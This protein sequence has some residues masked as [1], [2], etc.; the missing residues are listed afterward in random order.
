ML[1]TGAS[2][3]IGKAIAIRLAKEGY[4]LYLCCKNNI[5]S[6]NEFAVELS[7]NYKINCIPFKCDVSKYED[8]SDMFEKIGRI[9]I[10]INNAGIAYLGL[11]TDMNIDDWNS[12]INTNLTSAFLTSKL[13]IPKMLA[14]GE[15]K[16]INIS[17]MWGSVGAST[18]VAY[19]ASK[20]GLNGFTKALSKELA[21]SNISVNAISCGVID[22][23]MNRK[24]LTDEDL[25]NLEEE[26]PYG[27]MGT[28]SEV[29]NLVLSVIS[30]PNYMTG[31]IIMIDGGYI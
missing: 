3:G 1:V 25:Q 18:E 5:E 28:T 11:L 12:V 17:S 16:I 21:P 27:R 6:L 19:S 26:I 14:N 9:D 22:T 29:A 23:D 7:A 4:N 30:S 13:A 24:H 20:A 2:R 31:Q 10:V 8:V 15:G